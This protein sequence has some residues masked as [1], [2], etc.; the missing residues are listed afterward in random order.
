MSQKVPPKINSGTLVVIDYAD[1]LFYY[2]FYFLPKYNYRYVVSKT[3]FSEIIEWLLFKTLPL[4]H[5]YPTCLSP[6]MRNVI[7]R[8]L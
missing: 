6:R 7:P 4:A 8:N 5:N 2:Y 1:I 3:Y